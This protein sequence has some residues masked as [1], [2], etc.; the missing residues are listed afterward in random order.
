MYLMTPDNGWTPAPRERVHG[1]RK[2]QPRNPAPLLT[3]VGNAPEGRRGRRVKASRTGYVETEQRITD[4]LLGFNAAKGLV[5]VRVPGNSRDFDQYV[6]MPFTKGVTDKSDG[7]TMLIV[8]DWTHHG[9]AMQGQY[10]CDPDPYKNLKGKG[11]GNAIRWINVGRNKQGFLGLDY[12]P[13]AGKNIGMARSLAEVQNLCTA[14]YHFGIAPEKPVR[15]LECPSI[16][17]SV[18]GR[19][20]REKQHLDTIED[21]LEADLDAIKLPKSSRRKRT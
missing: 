10:A 11:F 19:V 1:A 2:L 13:S 3:Y 17:E 12:N 18:D 4:E 16:T 7:R 9:E 15:L 20:L 5:F 8:G 21:W 14:L 6:A